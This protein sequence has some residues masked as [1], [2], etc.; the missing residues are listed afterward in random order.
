MDVANAKYVIT[1]K[2]KRT[3][4]LL[5]LFLGSNLLALNMSSCLSLPTGG[6]I[7]YISSGSASNPESC[8]SGSPS[9]GYLSTSPAL[10]RPSLP[11]RAVGMV[12]DIA[13]PAKSGHP[14]GH[15]LEK[16][17]RSSTSTKSSITSKHGRQAPAIEKRFA[18]AIRCRRITASLSFCRNQ[19]HGAAVQGLR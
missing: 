2:E 17:G 19:W 11:S 16:A 1:L 14:R 15:G 7:A 5:L 13:P 3:K 18:H 9:G 8:M 4:T 12:V 10:S 6:V